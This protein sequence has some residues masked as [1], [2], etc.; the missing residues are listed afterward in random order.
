MSTTGEPCWIQLSTDDVDTAISF[1]GDLFGWSAGEPSEEYQGYRMLFRGDQ[2][3]AGLVPT[4]DG[5]H[6]T[7]TVFLATP[8]LAGTVERATAA[9]G[10]VLVEPMPVADLGS[11]AELADPAGAAVGAWEADTF[12]GFV[13]RA[14]DNAPSWFETLST[15]YDDAVA[16]YQQAFGWETHV[17]S[18]S[19]E[20]RYTTLGLNEDARAGIMDASSFLGDE[21]ARWQLYLQTSD[22]D[23]TIA[24]A[25]STGGEL[26]RAAED[27]PYGRIA[28]L[29]DPA[30][31]R[32]CVMRPNW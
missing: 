27:T 24:K 14:A 6:P 5:A 19:P 2:P 30:G 10:Q 1:Y 12:P 29:M 9:G 25:V 16:F 18:D 13:T 3:I 21:P 31:V 26:V 7:W 20:F 28:T 8:D 11:F 4:P 32:F 15:R 22:T 23:E 17:M